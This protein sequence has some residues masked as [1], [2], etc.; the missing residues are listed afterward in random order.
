MP[1]WGVNQVTSVNYGVRYRIHI[2]STNYI[3]T[4]VSSVLFFFSSHLL[5]STLLLTSIYNNRDLSLVVL[6]T[7]PFQRVRAVVQLR[8]TVSRYSTVHFVQRYL[9]GLPDLRRLRPAGRRRVHRNDRSS[10]ISLGHYY[11]RQKQLIPLDRT[12]LPR[13]IYYLLFARFDCWIHNK[14]ITI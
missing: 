5:P 12:L 2:M 6:P 7:R 11:R 14:Y 1:S 3:I 9:P 8:P 10:R 13:P 4:Q